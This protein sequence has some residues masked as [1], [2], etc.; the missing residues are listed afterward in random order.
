MKRR[1]GRPRRAVVQVGL[2]SDVDLDA[3][4]RHAAAVTRE[5]EAVHK[6]ATNGQ[7]A[8]VAP[9]RPAPPVFDA[10]VPF[11]ARV[12][13]ALTRLLGMIEAATVAPARPA[14]P[15]FDA[16]VPFEARVDS[17]LTRLLGM[18]EN[19][20]DGAKLADLV[21]AAEAAIKWVTVKHGLEEGRGWGGKLGGDAL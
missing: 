15:V 17:A 6:P 18:I 13:S 9:A 5:Y 2:P 16:S 10:S 4:V 14:P 3:V 12:D 20:E 7:A 19:P 11:E 1:P 21:K 8:T